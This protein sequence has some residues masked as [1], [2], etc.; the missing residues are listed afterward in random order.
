MSQAIAK[1]TFD[2]QMKSYKFHVRDKVSRELFLSDEM[3]DVKFVFRNKE[4][5][6]DKK[7]IVNIPAHKLI[8]AS[9]SGAFRD[10]FNGLWKDRKEVEID[11]SSPDAFKEFLQCFYLGHGTFT[12]EIISNVIHLVKKYE[13]AHCC[14]NACVRFLKDTLSPVCTCLSYSL[15]ILHDQT[16]LRKFC[17]EQIKA[18]ASIVLR[19][20]DFLNCDQALLSEILKLELCCDEE[21]V[22]NGCLEWAKNSCEKNG[23]NGNNTEML[24]NSLGDCLYLIRFGTMTLQEFTRCNLKYR[25]L[26][27][28][29]D[30]QEIINCITQKKFQSKFT[31]KPRLYWNQ[32]KIWKCQP[33]DSG[34]IKYVIAPETVQFTSNKSTLLGGIYCSDLACEQNI[35]VSAKIAVYWMNNSKENEENEEKNL[36]CGIFNFTKAKQAYLKLVTP[37]YIKG[38]DTY[39]IRLQSFDHSGLLKTFGRACGCLKSNNNLEITFKN[40][41]YGQFHLISCLELVDF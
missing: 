10:K 31:Q 8:L 12:N 18:N 1:P 34:T 25:G 23:L 21:I 40:N 11:D 41:S 28:E 7:Q 35:V 4:N 6:N 5:P 26:I 22:F 3:S 38:G 30:S 27:E 13:I 33:E 29:I 19:S 17:E 36:F 14:M 9:G 39:E 2:E 16:D 32:N 20:Y 24:R 37:I 15:S